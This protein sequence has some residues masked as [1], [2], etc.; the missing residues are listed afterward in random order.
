[1]CGFP[2]ALRGR[3]PRA[4]GGAMSGL[5][6]NIGIPDNTANTSNNRNTYTFV[7]QLFEVIPLCRGARRHR[8]PGVRAVP[9]CSRC[10]ASK[11]REAEKR[12]T[13]DSPLGKSVVSL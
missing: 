9:Y 8:P 1:M 13:I 11:A 7:L 4:R 5:A 12:E 10:A 2:T 3:R 6:F